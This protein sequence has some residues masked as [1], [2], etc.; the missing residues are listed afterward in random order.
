MGMQSDAGRGGVTEPNEFD[1]IQRR[2]REEERRR[3]ISLRVID[4][5]IGLALAAIVALVL[6]MMFY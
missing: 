1:E 6:K 2:E 4:I 5:L 3:L